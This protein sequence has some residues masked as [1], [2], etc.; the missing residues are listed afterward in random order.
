KT[1][2]GG[3]NWTA[4]N[5]GL[6]ASSVSSLAIDSALSTLYGGTLHGEGIFKSAN[7]GDCWMAVNSGPL[8]GIYALGIDHSAPPKL[9]VGTAGGGVF[10]ASTCGRCPRIIPPR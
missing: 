2:D 9:Y 10:L 4:A 1:T 8:P 7:S 5:T 3:A 6:I